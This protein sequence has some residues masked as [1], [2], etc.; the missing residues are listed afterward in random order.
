MVK[1]T[2]AKT[3]KGNG[4]LSFKKG[5]SAKQDAWAMPSRRG[6]PLARHCPGVSCS[7]PSDPSSNTHLPTSRPLLPREARFP[8]IPGTLLIRNISCEERAIRDGM[9][10]PLL[11]IVAWPGYR[12]VLTCWHCHWHEVWSGFGREGSGRRQNGLF[13]MCTSVDF[14]PARFGKCDVS[15]DIAPLEAT[16]YVMT[17]I[18]TFYF[19]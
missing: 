14:M 6:T 13:Y 15:M 8:L 9:D 7:L 17:L 16:K 3:E 10:L 19:W 11:G 2:P 5:F 4:R 12:D 18:E 1:D